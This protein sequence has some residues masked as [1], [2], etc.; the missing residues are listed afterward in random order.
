MFDFL[1]NQTQEV[2][3]LCIIFVALCIIEYVFLQHRAAKHIALCFE[4]NAQ[5]LLEKENMCT[6]KIEAIKDALTKEKFSLIDTYTMRQY[7]L[8]EDFNH[9]LLEIEK[10]Y[11]DKIAR[12]ETK[13]KEIEDLK[14]V[15]KHE[16]VQ[17]AA[18]TIKSEQED[19]RKQNREVLDERVKPFESQLENFKNKI[20]EFTLSGVKN[21]TSIV[22]Q[23]KNLEHNNKKIEQET[24][25]LIDALSRNQNVKGAYGEDI[26]EKILQYCG[27]QEGIHYKKQFV[28]SSLNLANDNYQI[29]R[30]DIVITLSNDRNVI[31]DS[32]VT[33]TSYLEYIEDK[34][35]LVNFKNAVKKR[36]KELADKNYSGIASIYQPD[37]VL[38]YMPIESSVAVIY[39]DIDIIRDA[40]N[41]K[42]IIVG[43]ASLLVAIKLVNQLMA[44]KKQLESVDTIVAAGSALYDTFTKMCE[45]LIDVRKR[46]D[47]T[48]SKFDTMLNRFKR[49]NK[50]NPSIFSQV[51]LL[52]SYGIAT[53]KSIPSELLHD[54]ELVLPEGE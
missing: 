24:K 18:Q 35:K 23:I 38:M 28:S 31:I 51:E 22:E 36:I 14:T 29:V 1:F 48:K 8:Q 17:I 7:T 34:T 9:K 32:K 53:K 2:Y 5:E 15:L 10:V 21:T 20:E 30:P 25:N 43:T 19:L 6:H 27:M 45:D 44:Q 37:F 13:I 47:D 26:L 52:K 40:Y 42:I 39:E 12:Y 11:T 50:S 16:F 46:L 4:N 54:N 3:I 41:N 33:L 49:T